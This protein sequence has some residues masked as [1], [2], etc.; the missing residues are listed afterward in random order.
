MGIQGVIFDKERLLFD[1]EPLWEACWSQVLA[2]EGSQVPEGMLCALKGCSDEEA[3]AQLRRFLGAH[4]PCDLLLGRAREAMGDAV[5]Q[6]P[7]LRRPGL[8]DLLTYLHDCQMPAGVTSTVPRPLM[9]AML[10][11]GD[12]AG[13]FD[14]IVSR[15]R[16]AG[17][18]SDTEALL[19]TSALLGTSTSRTVVLTADA[20]GVLAADAAGFPTCLVGGRGVHASDRRL[21]HVTVVD[22]LAEVIDLIEGGR[23]G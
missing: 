13:F 21:R 7:P 8:V 18:T 23:L 20:A 9:E 14:V 17:T 16:A 12:V 4:T 19:E 2:D 6:Q 1:L 22:G 15:R 11:R 5:A 10:A 3:R